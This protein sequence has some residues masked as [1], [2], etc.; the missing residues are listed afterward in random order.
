M[1]FFTNGSWRPRGPEIEQIATPVGEACLACGEA[2]QAD[3]CGVSVVHLG[4]QSDAYRPWHLACFQR[5]LGIVG[6]DA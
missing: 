1:R 5:S 2:I 4:W 6:A 3:D